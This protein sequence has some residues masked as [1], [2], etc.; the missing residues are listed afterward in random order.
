MESTFRQ[1][2]RLPLFPEKKPVHRRNRLRKPDISPAATSDI[3]I[4]RWI[5]N[6]I[7]LTYHISL[8]S[9]NWSFLDTWYEHEVKDLYLM[10]QDSP[11]A[12]SLFHYLCTRISD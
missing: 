10:N 5:G 2:L 12:E 1:E 6:G 7:T 4:L 9:P 3:E 8:S 11:L